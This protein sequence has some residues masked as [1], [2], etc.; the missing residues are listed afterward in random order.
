M[1]NSSFQ[2]A[3]TPKLYVSYPL[4]QYASGALDSY[5]VTSLSNYDYSTGQKELIQLIQLDPSKQIEI[6]PTT[7]SPSDA[8]HLRYRILPTND[9]VTPVL[10]SGLWNFDYFMILGHN[11]G[12]TGLNWN[13]YSSHESGAYYEIQRTNIVNYDGSGA[14]YDGWSLVEIENN[15][16][17][18]TRLL[19]FHLENMYANTTE[20]TTVKL[21]SLL[22]GKSFEFPQN[23]QMN[24]S[25]TF[26][27][28]VKQK[29]TI[30]G[31]TIST[32]NWTKPNNWIT[33]PFG[34]TN[35]EEGDNFQRR[36]GRRVWK[37]SF[38][39][40]APDKVMAQNMMMN[41][42]NYYPQDNHT[43]GAAENSS[44]YNIN[45]S[46]DFFS[47]VVNRSMGGHLPM[48][49]QLDKNDNS[50]SNYAIVRMN[51]NFTVTQKSPLLFNIKITLT[52]QI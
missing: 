38:D 51:K 46:P 27:Y 14:E 25:T 41:D 18:N 34:L 39:S 43:Q 19:H 15:A 30:S 50:A 3:S 24:T 10:S 17:D 22:W 45:N 16:D 31:K 5:D 36:T 33:E 28:G 23:C 37:M 8:S 13:I 47:A 35:G 40:L 48:V 12:T 20:N 29:S 49:L 32:A 2:I 44:L 6:L 9:N 4:F 11:F 7:E 1:A 42:N 26:E 21:G 52:E